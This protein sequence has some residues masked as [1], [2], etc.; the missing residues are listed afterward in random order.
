MREGL[1]DLH[2]QAQMLEARAEALRARIAVLLQ[3]CLHLCLS[4]VSAQAIRPVEEQQDVRLSLCDA[5]DLDALA[6]EAR[7]V[8]GQQRLK[9][10][11]AVLAEGQQ[12]RRPQSDEQRRGMKAHE[13]F[14]PLSPQNASPLVENHYHLYPYY[15]ENV[16]QLQDA[17]QNFSISH[18]SAY[19]RTLFNVI[20]N[21]SIAA[22]R[23]NL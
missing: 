14:N 18:V 2:A 20:M 9:I 21:I 4:E 7:L 12:A 16:S 22:I 13:L 23:G 1:L 8:R 3:Q 10:L 11:K 5:E 17:Q 19:E 15:I 6:R